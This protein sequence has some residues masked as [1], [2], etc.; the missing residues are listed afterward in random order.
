M[1][2]GILAA[3]PA[4]LNDGRVVLAGFGET[5][6]KSVRLNLLIDMIFRQEQSEG[7]KLAAHYSLSVGVR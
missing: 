6:D 1:G 5:I 4:D 7:T 2:P 3:N